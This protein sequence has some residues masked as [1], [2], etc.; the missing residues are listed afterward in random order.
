MVQRLAE[1]VEAACR[2]YFQDPDSANDG[3]SIDAVRRGGHHTWLS[4][5]PAAPRFVRR[6]F[7]KRFAFHIVPAVKDRCDGLVQKR[8]VRINQ[9][10]DR[11]ICFHQVREIGIGLSNNLR[12]HS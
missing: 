7:A 9:E 4:E 8:V 2:E 11:T 10:A 6:D 1:V 12:F 3:R 5:D